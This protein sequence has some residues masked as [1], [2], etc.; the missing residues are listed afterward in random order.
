MAGGKPIVVTPMRE[1]MQYKDVLIANGPEEFSQS[2]DR[3]IKLGQSAE[4]IIKI[5]KIAEQN[6]WENRAEDI[7]Q[8]IEKQNQPID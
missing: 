1:S 2:L 6:T 4:Y 3:A 7:L 8:E 5:K